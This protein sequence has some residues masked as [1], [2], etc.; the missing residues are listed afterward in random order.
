MSRLFE[1]SKSIHKL[2]SDIAEEAE[3]TSVFLDKENQ[4]YWWQIF[5]ES[6]KFIKPDQNLFSNYQ[7]TLIINVDAYIMEAE[8]LAGNELC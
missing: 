1:K 2:C 7:K 8:R 3:N 5:P 4:L 6:K